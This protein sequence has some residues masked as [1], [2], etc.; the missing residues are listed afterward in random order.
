MLM[1]RCVCSSLKEKEKEKKKE[2]IEFLMLL[3]NHSLFAHLCL[4]GS[5]K[6]KNSKGVSNQS[7]ILYLNQS[8]IESID[9]SSINPESINQFDF[10][11]SLCVSCTFC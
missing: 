2:K 10:F 5:Q 8:P 9:Q 7:N 6:Q 4:F 3:V 11:C 1:M